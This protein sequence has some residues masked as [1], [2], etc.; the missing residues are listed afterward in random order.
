MTTEKLGMTHGEGWHPVREAWLAQTEAFSRPIS[1]RNG[2][3]LEWRRFESVAVCVEFGNHA[4]TLYRIESLSPG[5][6]D[7]RRVLEVLKTLAVQSGATL[8]GNAHAY[9]TD[10]CPSP[11]QERLNGFYRSCG[12]SVGPGPYHWVT[13][14]PNP[15]HLPSA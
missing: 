11:D 2:A 4:H 14:P 8:V 3:E 1:E 9:P 13:Y 15:A 6:G 12:F 5:C 7:A 10:E